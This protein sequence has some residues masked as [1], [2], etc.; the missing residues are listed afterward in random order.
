MIVA[1]AVV[2]EGAVVVAGVVVTVVDVV[3]T[4]H[5]GPSIKK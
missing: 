1:A 5:S 4:P 3:G 2:V